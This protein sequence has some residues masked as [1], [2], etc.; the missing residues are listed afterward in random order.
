MSELITKQTALDILN[1]CYAEIELD[2]DRPVNCYEGM[3]YTRLKL[4]LTA[5]KPEIHI[6]LLTCKDCEHWETGWSCGGALHY[7][8]MVDGIHG[9]NFFCGYAE[10]CKD[11]YVAVLK[12][13][14]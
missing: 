9:P 14:D 8:P 3:F 1:K 12:E 6:P 10:P 5:V 7:C 13:V 4:E 11:E 2:Y